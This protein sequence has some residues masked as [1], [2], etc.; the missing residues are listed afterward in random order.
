MKNIKIFGI[1]I[2]TALLF[3]ACNKE[4]KSTPEYA[5]KAYI[6]AFHTGD[7]N[8][9]YKYTA[10]SNHKLIEQLQSMMNKNK[11]KLEEIKNNTVEIQQDT[12]ISINDSVAECHCRY[13]FNG[14]KRSGTYNL[15]KEDGRW[16][17]DITV[18]V[19]NTV[20]ISDK[21]NIQ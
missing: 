20:P 13:L 21:K 18:P 17:V 5:A 6:V 16:V 10:K 12:L 4:D 8:T 19:A 9:L 7:F 3:W 14:K 15:Y 1:V 11:D 2:L